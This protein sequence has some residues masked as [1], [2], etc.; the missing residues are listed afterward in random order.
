LIARAKRLIF[1]DR[2]PE[3]ISEDPSFYLC[4]WC[5]HARRCHDGEMLRATCRSC[6][7]VTPEED[8]SW[9]CDR[10]GKV[11]S[12]PEQQAGCPAHL[13]IPDLIRGEQID[14]GEEWVSYRMPDG[15]TWIDGAK[16]EDAKC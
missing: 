14:A 13:F 1:A 9:H 5:D 2:P 10:W 16:K 12:Y 6:L 3:R 8:G 7:H 11:L 15:S 4:R